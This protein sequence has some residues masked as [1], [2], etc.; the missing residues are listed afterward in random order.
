[1]EIRIYI[2]GDTQRKGKNSN[3][4]LR[5]GFH[6]FLSELIE[7]ARD[8]GIKFQI[9]M[10]GSKSETFKYFLI[11]NKNHKDSFVSFLIDSDAPVGE[12]E[13]AKSFLQ[14]QNP[15][16]DFQ[17][18]GEDQCHLMVQISESW[19]L[20]DVEALRSFYGKKFQEK[21][22]PKT[23]DVEKIDKTK[24]ENSIKDATKKTEKGEYHKT[25]H[26][27]ALFQKISPEKARNSASFCRRLFD[28]VSGKIG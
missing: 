25:R 3:I 22:I 14:K 15:G 8:K 26:G 16:W 17:N 4:S 13:T 23:D 7:D 18:V 11:G 27:P 19:F 12:K 28:V 20:A 2:E 5:Q 9:V 21:K 6:T 10:S 24:V 1:M